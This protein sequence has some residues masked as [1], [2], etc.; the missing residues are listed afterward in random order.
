MMRYKFKRYEDSSLE[1][2]GIQRYRIIY[3]VR[4]MKAKIITSTLLDG[5]PSGRISCEL[6]NWSGKA[7]KVPKLLLSKLDKHSELNSPGVYLLF[8]V[9]DGGSNRVYIGEAELVLKRL[10]QHEKKIPFWNE[11]LIFFSKDSS[12]NKAHI[13]YM[14]NIL[15]DRAISVKQ[16]GV[17]NSVVPTK[18]ALS[19]SDK[20]VID[21]F[22]ENIII[23]SNFLGYKV[24]VDKRE[25]ISKKS[26]AFYL[27][28]SRG[29]EAIGAPSPNGFVVYK[30]SK[31]AREVTDGLTSSFLNFRNRLIGERILVLNN[32]DWI[33]EDD[34]VFK[35][36]STAAVIILGRNANGLTEWKTKKGERLKDYLDKSLG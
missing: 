21:E 28:S 9:D 4:K 32:G 29:G 30:G 18:S 10:L 31:A 12:L 2:S 1:Y 22:T 34:Y 14:E 20:I 35:S 25:G 24:F 5:E 19:E 8:W 33:F 17:H 11:A 23:I 16:F 27:S 26:D 13:K 6:A 15:Y 36:P 7:F 3:I